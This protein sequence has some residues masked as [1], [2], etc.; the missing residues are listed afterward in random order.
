MSFSCPDPYTHG[1]AVT[2]VVRPGRPPHPPPR[3][4]QIYLD[5][6]LYKPKPSP[7]PSPTS[8]NPGNADPSPSSGGTAA[9]STPEPVRST[10]YTNTET[11]TDFLRG[12]KRA[13]CAEDA[14]K[15]W[16]PTWTSSWA[17]TVDM[18]AYEARSRDVTILQILLEA[19]AELY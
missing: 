3:L 11:L 2:P 18:T 10:I 14:A 19:K 6:P 17:Q 16:R 15:W 1:N 5:G 12:D 13:T 9:P 8:S 7:K 4:P